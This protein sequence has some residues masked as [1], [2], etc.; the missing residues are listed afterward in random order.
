MLK[1]SPYRSMLIKFISFVGV[2]YI[3][4]NSDRADRATAN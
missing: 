1:Q 2:Y 4:L 3:R